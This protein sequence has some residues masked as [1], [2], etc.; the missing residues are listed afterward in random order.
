LNVPW[1]V[2]L[3]VDVEPSPQLI[4]YDHGPLPFASLKLG[5]IE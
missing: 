5:L 3:P 2:L 4:V 1:T